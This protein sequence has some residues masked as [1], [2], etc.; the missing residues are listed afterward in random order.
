[1]T[2]DQMFGFTALIVVVLYLWFYLTTTP[3]L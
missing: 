3:K 2:Q 1:M